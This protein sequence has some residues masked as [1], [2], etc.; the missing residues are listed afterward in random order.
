MKIIEQFEP[1]FNDSVTTQWSI[2]ILIRENRWERSV[3]DLSGLRQYTY[4]VPILY[5][6]YKKE[7]VYKNKGSRTLSIRLKVS[8]SLTGRY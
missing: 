4:T 3:E 7:S 1:S 2:S 5:N 6:R 8:V